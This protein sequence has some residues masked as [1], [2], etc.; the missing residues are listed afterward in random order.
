[1][2]GRVANAL[3]LASA[4]PARPASAT[5][6]TLLTSSKAWQA[7]SNATVLRIEFMVAGR[8]VNL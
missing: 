8:P 7:A 4:S 3:L 1:V 6:V 2:A 5:R